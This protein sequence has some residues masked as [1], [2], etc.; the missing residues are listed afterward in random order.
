MNAQRLRHLFLL[1]LFNGLA[2]H[3]LGQCQPGNIGWLSKMLRIKHQ[4]ARPAQITYTTKPS[5][6]YEIPFFLV[7]YSSF[8]KASG[9][10]YFY[11]WMD[12]QKAT[13][14]W[15]SRRA[16]VAF[17]IFPM[18][19]RYLLQPQHVSGDQA[20]VPCFLSVER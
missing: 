1:L 2:L 12:H 8:V 13:A 5:S 20:S 15:I 10:G 19:Q 17:S 18:G 4:F 14:R 11:L 3:A 16:M 7:V 6:V 9:Q